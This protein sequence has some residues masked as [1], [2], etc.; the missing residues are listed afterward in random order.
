VVLVG[1][2]ALQVTMLLTATAFSIYKRG[3][4]P[5]RGAAKAGWST[6]AFRASALRSR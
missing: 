4:R 6:P 1:A 2:P 3:R 5:F